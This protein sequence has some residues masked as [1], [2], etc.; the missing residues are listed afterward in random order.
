MNRF[1]LVVFCAFAVSA[2]MGPTSVSMDPVSGSRSD[3]TIVMQTSYDPLN[4]QINWTMANNEAS[5]R[6]QSWG[7]AR[8]LPF[9]D[10]QQACYQV[11]SYS[12]NCREI[13]AMRTYQCSVN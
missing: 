3:G 4:E 9:N 11:D 13:Q 6:C 1:A 2:C 8:A 5:R 10:T 12:G 7:Y